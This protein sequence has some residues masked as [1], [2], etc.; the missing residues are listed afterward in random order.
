[1]PYDIHKKGGKFQVLDKKG[2]VLSK[3][4]T[5][6]KAMAQERLLNY[7]HYLKSKGKNPKRYL[8][9]Q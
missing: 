8:K 7:I 5:K 9:N 3:G 6:K 4:T 1:M 2:D